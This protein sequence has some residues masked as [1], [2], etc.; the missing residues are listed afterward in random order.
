MV[1]GSPGWF[2][3]FSFYRSKGK[4]RNEMNATLPARLKVSS[5]SVVDKLKYFA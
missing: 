1:Q 4:F 2:N 5:A 3:T